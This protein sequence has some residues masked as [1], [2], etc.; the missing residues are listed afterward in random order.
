MKFDGQKILSI[1]GLVVM[2][3]VTTLLTTR[4]N[5]KKLESL[6]DDKWNDRRREMRKNERLTNR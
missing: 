5:E 6:V 4:M 1:M 2:G 3:T